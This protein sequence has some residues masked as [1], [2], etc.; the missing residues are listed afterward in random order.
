MT[1]QTGETTVI[2]PQ[3]QKVKAEQSREQFCVGVLKE[4]LKKEKRVALTPMG[5]SILTT[6]G[7][8][9]YVETGSGLGAN[10]DDDAYR[11]AG[12]EIVSYQKLIHSAN[13]LVKVLPLGISDLQTIPANKIIFSALNPN[14][15]HREVVQ[16]MLLKNHTGIAYEFYTDQSG[17][18]PFLHLMNEI[19]GSTAVL[20]AAELLSNERGGK[21]VMLGGVTGLTP[22]EIIVLGTDTAA[23]YAV[24]VALGL[25][26]IVKVFDDDLGGLLRFKE[27]FGQQLYTSTL[28]YM[29]LHKAFRSADVVINA[30]EKKIHE[31]SYIIDND[32]VKAMKDGAIIIDT[33][34]DVGSIISTSRPTTLE[35]PVYEKYGVI[36]YCVPNLPSRVSRTASMAISDVLTPVLLRLLENRSILPLLKSNAALRKATYTYLGMLTNT[37]LAKRFKLDARDLNLILPLF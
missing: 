8:K 27:L 24:R 13:I 33:K 10:Y 4:D 18:N 15:L 14:T 29:V 30:R 7:F 5:V 6:K 11:N 37:V 32:L 20:I 17:I 9:V 21:G 31:D 1:P 12:A 23:E 16:L 26:A 28:N 19:T 35:N 3:P 2:L 22:S 25:G 36:H 34:I